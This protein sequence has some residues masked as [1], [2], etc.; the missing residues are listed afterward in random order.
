MSDD[1]HMYPVKIFEYSVIQIRTKIEQTLVFE[2]S[3]QVKFEHQHI[4]RYTYM[5]M[6]SQNSTRFVVDERWLE[7]SG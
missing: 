7:R 2:V 6:N 3:R 5:V 4:V 1:W